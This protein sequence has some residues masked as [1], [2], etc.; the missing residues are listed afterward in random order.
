MLLDYNVTKQMYGLRVPSSEYKLIQTLKNEHG[1]DPSI[2]AAVPGFQVLVPRNDYAA[3]AFAEH[4]T[5]KALAQ[6]EPVL[7]QIAAS[8]APD[9]TANIRVPADKELWPFQRASVAYAL[10]RRNCL[11]A[12]QPGLGKT[13]IAIAWANEIRAKNV[14]VLCPA[15]IRGQWAKRIREWSTMFPMEWPHV[16][17]N[18]RNGTHPTAKWTICSYDLA[19]TPAIGAAL[20]QRR[21]DALIL[22]EAH[23]LKTIDAGRTRAIFGGGEKRL[24]DPI[25]DNAERILALTGTPLPN[26]H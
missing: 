15:S 2:T 3:A 6:M 17:Y 16:I 24:F 22:D 23:Y 25:A 9:H 19:R 11:V 18:G 26:R 13:P 4:A 14:L 12:D 8:W 7:S 1:L 5:P 10:E 21:Y 20:A